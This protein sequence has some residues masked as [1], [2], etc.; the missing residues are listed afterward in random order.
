MAIRAGLV[1]DPEGKRRMA[2]F[3]CPDV[4]ATP[5]AILPGVVR[6][7]SG[8]V[9]CE[10]SRAPLGVETPRPWSDRAMARTTP[11]LVALFPLVTVLALQLR[12]GGQI[13]VPVPAWSHNAEPTFADCVALVRQHR[14]RAR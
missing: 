2:A 7:W 6:R 10:E 1:A 12:Q 4:A 11:V 14:W 8:E 9:T 13:P 5:V 3:C